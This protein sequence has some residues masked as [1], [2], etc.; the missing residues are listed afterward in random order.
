MLVSDLD[1]SNALRIE[2]E[3]IAAFGTRSSGGRLTNVVSPSGAPS[4][5]KNVTVPSGAFERAQLGLTLL[6]E[7]VNSLVEASGA[8]GISNADVVHSLDLG[9]DNGGAAK[10]YLTYSLLGI[11]MREKRVVKRRSDSRYRLPG[12]E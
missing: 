9:S 12:L 10:D 3:L 2:A 4:K 8:D 7:S 6:L 5:R 11:L 1:E